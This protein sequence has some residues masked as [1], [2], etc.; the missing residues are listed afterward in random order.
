[1][2][3]DE[4]RLTEYR[5][6][7]FFCLIRFFVFIKSISADCSDAILEYFFRKISRL[8]Y[9]Q[10]EYQ[11]NRRVYRFMGKS[12]YEIVSERVI[13]SIEEAIQTNAPLVW[14]KPWVFANPPRNFISQRAYSGIN[15]LLLT[16]GEYIT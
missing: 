12:V 14:Q 4:R 1:M 11:R 16:G 6:A 10:G 8:Q 9:R 5:Q 13:A 2:A 7:S 3:K 15:T